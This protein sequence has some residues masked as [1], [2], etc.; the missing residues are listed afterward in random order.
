MRVAH[1][2]DEIGGFAPGDD[3]GTAQDPLEG[4]LHQVLSVAVP[5]TEMPRDPRQPLHVRGQALGVEGTG[6]SKVDM[7]AM[8]RLRGR[9]RNGGRPL[10]FPLLRR[11]TTMRGV[12]AR[13][14]VSSAARTLGPWADPHL[15]ALI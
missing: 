2:L 12:A 14:T 7:A 4:V 13:T 5:A 11:L 3:A 15:T 10:T 8:V 9:P 1:G 6:N